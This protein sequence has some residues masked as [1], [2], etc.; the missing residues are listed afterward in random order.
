MR[1]LLTAA[2]LVA[3]CL[4]AVVVAPPT[5]GAARPEVIAPCASSVRHRVSCLPLVLRPVGHPATLGVDTWP[6]ALSPADVRAAYGWADSGGAGQAI[7]I[8]DA[9][10]DPAIREDL[11]T[12]DTEFGLTCDYCLSVVNEYGGAAP[13][14]ATTRGWGVEQSLD[15]EYAHATA[16]LAHI[17]LVEANTATTAA[18]WTAV[19]Y[20][21]AHARY[22]SMSFGG[23]E[24]AGELAVDDIFRAHPRVSFFAAAGDVAGAVEYPAASPDVVAVGGTQLDYTKVTGRYAGES[25]WLTGGGGCSTYELASAPQAAF[26]GYAAAGCYGARATPDVA[27]DATPYTGVEVYDSLGLVTG[28]VLYRGWFQVGG[29]SV[30]TPL[31]AAHAAATGRRVDAATLYSPALRLYPAH[32]GGNHRNCT[33]GRYNLCD[34]LGS[35]SVHGR[36]L[37][38]VSV[39][40]TA[41]YS[42]IYRWR[43]HRYVPWEVRR[44]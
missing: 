16:P 24:F 42:L 26:P 28:G 15:V 18:I 33:V 36:K 35:W 19:A 17:I 13:L 31:W 3:A 41:T 39:A 25:A 23:T 32:Y 6:D 11:G 8:V 2:A 12:F 20:A 38:T 29:T 7:A 30:A 44:R 40:L 1:R 4:V 10:A 43:G 9:Y 27:A 34:G 5:T 37:H 14:P 22:V 21:A